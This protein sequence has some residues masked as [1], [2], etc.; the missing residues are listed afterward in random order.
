MDE[1]R[2]LYQMF[3]QLAKLSQIIG[4]IL[5]G[6][7]TTR[8]KQQSYIQGSD[9]VVTR[10]DHE[11]TIWRF[12]L[13]K[14]LQGNDNSPASEVNVTP[15]AGW[16]SMVECCFLLMISANMNHFLIQRQ[17]IYATMLH[18]SYFIDHS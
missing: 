17:S 1:E 14:V 4:H 16:Y 2:P 9:N 6:L 10:L 5:Q 12:G 8:A 18:C 7:Y 13:I 11:L 15:V 3:L